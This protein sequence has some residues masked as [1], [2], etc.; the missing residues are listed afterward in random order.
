MHLLVHLWS[1]TFV[2][3]PL[4]VF[5]LRAFRGTLRVEHFHLFHFLRSHLRQVPDKENQLPAVIVLAGATPRGHSREANSVVDDLIDLP[6]REV[7]RLGLAQVRCLWIEVLS[8]L[9]FTASVI[10]VAYGAMVGEVGAR[11]AENLR[12]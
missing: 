10:A 3:K 2:E 1:F 8:D 5:L 7:L 11:L 4:F 6:V 12:G 9:R